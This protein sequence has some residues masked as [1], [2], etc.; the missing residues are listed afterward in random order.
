MND[1]TPKKERKIGGE[2]ARN[3]GMNKR[4]KARKTKRQG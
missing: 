2:E 3:G 1:E 4:N